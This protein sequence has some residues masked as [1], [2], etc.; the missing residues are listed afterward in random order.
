MNSQEL[1]NLQEAYNQVYELDENRMASRMEKMPSAPAKVGKATHSIKDIAPSKAPS[2]KEKAKARKALGLNEVSNAKVAA[3]GKARQKNVDKAFDKLDDSR[4]SSQNLATA[5]SKQQ[6]NQRL[7]AK[8]DKRNE[9]VDLYD[10][11][12]SHLLDE[13]YADT[14]E[15]ATAIMVNMS[16]D[17]RES[18]MEEI[19]QLDES[20]KPMTKKKLDR[21]ETKSQKEKDR[22]ASGESKSPWGGIGNRR[23]NQMDRVVDAFGKRGIYYSSGRTI[24]PKISK[25]KEKEN[26][27]R[28][29]QKEQT[30]LY[31][32][33]LSH[34][35]DE[36]YAD[37]EQAAQV[38]MVN[39][40]EDW[41]ESICEGYVE[42]NKK[43]QRRMTDSAM[44][45]MDS[46]KWEQ[47]YSIEN[48]RDTQT[49]EVSQAKAA[50]N[51]K[52]G[53]EKRRG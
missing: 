9:E 15:A 52:R 14:Q 25:A 38:I 32:I 37:T 21:I 51:K 2:P 7:S 28:G 20:Y 44:R 4:G 11:I 18:I 29:T 10:I 5:I 12:L 43:R 34:L 33:I 46:D 6:K 42:L 1:R 41:R 8:R 47:A 31:D 23:T 13:G 50:A 16:E 53:E 19:E 48:E 39:M 35:L 30:D 36:G 3:V 26:R 45:K 24:G 17:W 40:S 27:A 49:P 22:I